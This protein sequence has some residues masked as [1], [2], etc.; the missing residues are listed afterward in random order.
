MKNILHVDDNLDHLT[1]TRIYLESEDSTF[2]I[3]EANTGREAIE[4]IHQTDYSC[5]LI[6]YV[7]LDVDGLELS[8]QIKEL[9][10]TPIVLYTGRGSKEIENKAAEIGVDLYVEKMSELD[11][12][13]NLAI[14]INGLIESY[15]ASRFVQLELL[16]YRM[17]FQNCGLSYFVTDNE[18]D[19]LW[20]N[21]NMFNDDHIVDQNI[22]SLMKNHGADLDRIQLTPHENNNKT[23]FVDEIEYDLYSFTIDVNR[24]GLVFRKIGDAKLM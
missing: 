14:N 7:M 24:I 9:T 6:D 2:T 3:D 23:V 11:H 16:F 15:E 17:F 19:I 18:G 8:K 20:A 22:Y 4:K 5:I 10:D 1:L 21:Q 13:H 12:Y